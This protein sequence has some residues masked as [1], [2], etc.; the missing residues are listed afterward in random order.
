[1]RPELPIMS[2]ARKT[3]GEVACATDAD[4][5][6]DHGIH[7]IHGI[8]QG[9]VGGSRGDQCTSR[10]TLRRDSTKADKKRSR[11]TV[12]PGARFTARSANRKLAPLRH[13]PHPGRPRPVPIPPYVCSTA[14]SIQATC[15]PCRWR[16]TADQPGG[17]GPMAGYQGQ[18]V[19][20]LDAQAH[21]LN[22]DQ[23]T[24]NEA[25]AIDRAFPDGVPQDGWHGRGRDLR[26]HDFGDV[27]SAHGARMLD[28]AAAGYRK[29]H[30]G[31]VWAY[32]HAWPMVPRP[33]WGGINV[34]ASVETP[35]GIEL[36]RRRGYPS[37]IVVLEFPNGERAFHL[38]GASAR[39]VPCPAE[40]RGLTCVQ[41]RLCLD[42]D[43][44]G[45]N[46]AIAFGPHGPRAGRVR[47][48]LIQLGRGPRPLTPLESGNGT[49]RAPTAADA[50]T[51][52]T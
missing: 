29:R 39:I 28:R 31:T 37:A 20:R 22:A 9:G 51:G 43:L 38:P 1:M 50:A 6:H 13:E 19:R 34:I 18:H 45:L 8:C 46:I 33:A 15:P 17:C 52:A 5:V 27:G 12:T 36:A 25:A 49:T 40:T 41:C 48:T 32:T 2:E 35:D 7:G 23:V 42:R 21:G 47:E 10:R 11:A 44:L 3:T 24:A 4:D 26:L 30:G 14:T 16:G